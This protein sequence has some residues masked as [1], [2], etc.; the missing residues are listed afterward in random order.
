M[1]KDP[2]LSHLSLVNPAGR[3]VGHTTGIEFQPGIGDIDLVRKNMN[4]RRTDVKTLKIKKEE[5]LKKELQNFFRCIRDGKIRKVT[6]EE[7]MKALKLAFNVLE[8]AEI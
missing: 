7:G 3:K 6:G 4:S 2:Q 8:E 5:P 1:F